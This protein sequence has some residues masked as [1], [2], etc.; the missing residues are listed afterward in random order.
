MLPDMSVNFKDYADETHFVVAICSGICV[1][2]FENLTGFLSFNSPF[3]GLINTPELLLDP[4]YILLYYLKSIKSLVA[5]CTNKQ[6]SFRASI[7]ITGDIFTN[8]QVDQA[9]KID[10]SFC[11]NLFSFSVFFFSKLRDN[12]LLH[13]LYWKEH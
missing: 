8:S 3:N 7:P 10:Y 6:I 5:L 4:I 1:S 13:L 2:F 11:L 9:R 12:V